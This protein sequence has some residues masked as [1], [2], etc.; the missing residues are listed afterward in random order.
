M[1]GCRSGFRP[2][3]SGA[4]AIK[5]D[6]TSQLKA[7]TKEDDSQVEKLA[8]RSG[9]RMTVRDDDA[10]SIDSQ[11]VRN[12]IAAQFPH[13]RH[14]PVEPV[15]PGGWDNRTFRLG[16]TMS[17]RLPSRRAYVPQVEKEH[18][19]LPRLAKKLPLPI[20]VPLARGVPGEGYP[21]P[22]SIYRWLDGQPADR[23]AISDINRFATDVAGFLAALHRIEAHNGAP[24]GE[25]NFHRG[26]RLS[27][28]D[29]ETRAAIAT[30]ADRIDTAAAT[31]LW[32]RALASHWA[33]SPVWVHG[34]IAWGNLL[35]AD[36]ALCAVIDFGSSAVGDPACDLV[37]AWTF[38]AGSSRE[39]FRLAIDLDH[40]TW[41]RARG[42]A[43]WKALITAAGHDGNQREAAQSWQVIEEVLSEHR[44][45]P[46]A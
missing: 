21:F 29:A 1:F 34:D 23:N 38:L 6:Y 42:W 30:L 17:V 11:L 44:S 31:S 22:W 8:W 41:S 14:L 24:A 18:R 20:P 16:D 4:T 12:L 13:W 9:V 43:L 2:K 25:H 35:V 26:G 32:D 7:A 10:P 15:L 40:D 33:N 5:D 39:A 27:V 3:L 36:G 45:L 37:I 46:M 28:Y 19:W